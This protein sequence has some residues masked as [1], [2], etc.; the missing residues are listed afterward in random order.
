MKNL[1]L[2]AT[3][4]ISTI[5]IGQIITSPRTTNGNVIIGASI[6]SYDQGVGQLD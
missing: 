6:F 2:F 5:T 3:L 1:F 4:F